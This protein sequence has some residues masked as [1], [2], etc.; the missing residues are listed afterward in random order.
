MVLKGSTTTRH[1]TR[2]LDILSAFS[3]E[4]PELTPEALSKRT[5]IPESTL[6]RLLRAL[7][8]YGFLSLGSGPGRYVPGFRALELGDIAAHYLGVPEH[9]QPLLEELARETGETA[10]FSLWRGGNVRTCIAKAESQHRLRDV[11][12]VGGTYALHLGASG[13]AIAASLRPDQQAEL[14]SEC[15]E[16]I[17][18]QATFL[19]VLA[20]IRKVGVAIT[21]SERVPGVL[22]VAAAV[23]GSDGR[24]IGSVTVS[25]PA[26]RLQPRADECAAAVQRVAERLSRSL[27]TLSPSVTRAS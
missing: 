17:E 16:T 7:V 3:H 5:G 14:A 20:E 9:V 6:F 15:L 19:A 11:V 18:E 27:S 1:N 13:K 12:S 23:L 8:E 24:V 26:A 22:A 25:G 4:S 10:N 2:V 21:Q